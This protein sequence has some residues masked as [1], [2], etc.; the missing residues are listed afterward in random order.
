MVRIFLDRIQIRSGL[1]EFLSVRIRFRVSNIRN[2]SVSECSKV[3]LFYDVDIY[4][5][6]IRQKLTLSVSDSVFEHKYENK[7]NISDIRPYP[8]RFHPYTSVSKITSAL[9]TTPKANHL[10]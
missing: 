7:Y 9:L 1:E 4:Y 2:R 3:T 10:V 6:L 5:N 8:I